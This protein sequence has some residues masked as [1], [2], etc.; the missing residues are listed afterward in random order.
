MRNVIKTSKLKA[1]FEQRPLREQRL[2]FG[3]LGLL[4]VLLVWSLAVAPAWHAWRT[5]AQAHA[6]LE[7]DFERM[8][9]MAHEA[10][11]LK[12]HPSMTP[13]QAKTWVLESTHKLG[14]ASVNTQGDSFQISFSDVAPE[15]LASWL[16]QARAHAQLTP[17]QANWKRSSGASADH[18]MWEGTLL[19]TPSSAVGR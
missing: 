3:L 8:Q 13:E 7:A 17:I 6:E 11:T 18:V 15:V 4:V 16:A 2:L 10:N 1:W 19:M 9:A 14:K 12:A 5:S